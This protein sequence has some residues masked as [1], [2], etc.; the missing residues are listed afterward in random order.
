MMRIILVA[1]GI[2]T[3]F[4]STPTIELDPPNASVERPV[5]SKAS[6]LPVAEIPMVM[7]SD[8]GRESLV[9]ATVPRLDSMPVMPDLPAHLAPP[10]LD[11]PPDLGAALVLVDP[12]TAVPTSAR[13][14]VRLVTALSLNMRTGPTKNARV[15][16]ALK[17]G[18]AAFVTGAPK[19]GWVPVELA[20][21]GRRGWVFGTF[22]KPKES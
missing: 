18:D 6:T 3:V 21:D 12:G 20:K 8:V 14:D 13:R 1:F 19:K 22:L 16:Q 10:K 4:W 5:Y 17:Q 2:L 7:A 11:T 15:L 9:F